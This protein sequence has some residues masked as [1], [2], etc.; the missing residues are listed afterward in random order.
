MQVSNSTKVIKCGVQGELRSLSVLLE[1][2]IYL[3][4][5]YYFSFPFVLGYGLNPSQ[6]PVLRRELEGRANN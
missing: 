2:S 4:E 6:G 1:G 5:I 3:R